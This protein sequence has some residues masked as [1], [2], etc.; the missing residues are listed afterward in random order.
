MSESAGFVPKLTLGTPSRG[1]LPYIF[2]GCCRYPYLASFGEP[3]LKSHTGAGG[4]RDQPLPLVK[5][6]AFDQAHDFAGTNHSRLSAKLCGPDWSEKIDFQ[7][8][9]GERLAFC[10]G[11]EVGNA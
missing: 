3:S 4:A 5:D 1:C 11:A 7:L 8:D 10:E 9:G 2:E 6:V